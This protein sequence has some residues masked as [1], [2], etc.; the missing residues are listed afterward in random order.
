M[1]S[2]SRFRATSRFR[3]GPWVAFDCRSTPIANLRG[4]LVSL[5]A[6]TVSLV[7][8][9]NRHIAVGEKHS[10]FATFSVRENAN[11]SREG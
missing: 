6:A 8:F 4:H 7:V 3:W 2:S 9:L 5:P 1:E 11:G 10:C